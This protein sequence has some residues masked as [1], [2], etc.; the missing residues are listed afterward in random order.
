MNLRPQLHAVL[1]ATLASLLAACASV[2]SPVMQRSGA[3]AP[4][5]QAT[6]DAA[7]KQQSK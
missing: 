2:S 4:A 6:A 1:A 5:P 3:M 7:A